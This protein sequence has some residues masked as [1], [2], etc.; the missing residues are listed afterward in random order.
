MCCPSCAVCN[1]WNVYKTFVKD[2]IFAFKHHIYHSEQNLWNRYFKKPMNCRVFHSVKLRCKTYWKKA[3]NA[4]Q[5]L[6]GNVWKFYVN[7]ILQLT[8]RNI[9]SN[10]NFLSAWIIISSLTRDKEGNGVIAFLDVKLTRNCTSVSYKDKRIENR[11][12]EIEA[13][14]FAPTIRCNIHERLERQCDRDRLH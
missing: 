6:E 12:K 8:T 10:F 11:R 5:T 7:D 14:T 9:W 3:I 2:W 4:F 1:N 13:L